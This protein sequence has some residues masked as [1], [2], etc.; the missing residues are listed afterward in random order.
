MKP[1]EIREMTP[2]ELNR[3]VDETRRELFNLKMQSHTGQ[4]EDN[5][6][7]RRTRRDVARLLTEKHARMFNQAN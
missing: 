6:Q 5:S 4:L 1:A 2:D 7:I 3:K